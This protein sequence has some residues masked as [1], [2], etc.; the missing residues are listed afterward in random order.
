MPEDFPWL[1]A[2]VVAAAVAWTVPQILK[3]VARVISWLVVGF[4]S[5]VS[6]EIVEQLRVGL[7]PMWGADFKDAMEEALAP[8]LSEL[9]VNGGTSVKD[10]V[11]DIDANL[12]QL[13][14][15]LEPLFVDYRN[16]WDPPD[17]TPA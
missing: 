16:R 10:K 4:A 14:Q 17:G 3:Q 13:Q 5:F 12:H 8:I 9:T 2:L 11:N 15:D 7:A 1:A 6:R